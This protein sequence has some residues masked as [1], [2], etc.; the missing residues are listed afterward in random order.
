M[1]E[2]LWFFPAGIKERQ[3]EIKED[4]NHMAKALVP[5]PYELKSLFHLFDG[6][7]SGQCTTINAHAQGR[8]A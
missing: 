8:A 2:L 3:W 1:G 6:F 4:E 7:I 5:S